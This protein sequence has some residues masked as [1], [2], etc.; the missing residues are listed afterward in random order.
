[1]NNTHVNNTHSIGP[2]I[3]GIF[4]II[5]PVVIYFSSLSLILEIIGY[6]GCLVFNSIAL[7]VSN[8]EIEKSNNENSDDLAYTSKRLSLLGMFILLLFMVGMI[9]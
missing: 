5:T 1:M 2:V 4:T 6:L 9:I 8:E 7:K 3:L